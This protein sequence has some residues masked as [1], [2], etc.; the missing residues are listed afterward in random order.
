MKRFFKTAAGKTVL[1]LVC[2]V[3]LLVLA[4]CAVG[5][6]LVVSADNGVFYLRTEEEA[7]DAWMTQRLRARAAECL[8]LVLNGRTAEVSDKD[9]YFM[10]YNVNTGV[11]Q[12]MSETVTRWAGQNDFTFA[13]RLSE[14]TI[15]NI[16][17]GE[18]TIQN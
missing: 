18:G 3:F 11:T 5:A 13:V 2:I 14:G 6:G 10:V 1:V 9:L 4:A 7:K 8:L 17:L 16:R 15:Q 12:Y